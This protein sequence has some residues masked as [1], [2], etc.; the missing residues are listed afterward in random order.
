MKRFDVYLRNKITKL[1]IYLNELPIRDYRSLR[2][3]IIL[4]DKCS[5]LLR[6]FAAP[7]QGRT[8]LKIKIGTVSKIVRNSVSNAMTF[9]SSVFPR[10]ILYMKDNKNTAVLTTSDA[11]VSIGKYTGLR[12]RIMLRANNIKLLFGTPI[13][14]VKNRVTLDAKRL[15][16]TKTVFEKLSNSFVLTT[17]AVARNLSE[18][19]TKMMTVK[20]SM[21]LNSM[22]HAVMLRY[23]RLYE[24]DD[25]TL[26]SLDNM[27]LRDLDYIEL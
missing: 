18:T 15:S 2:H 21:V 22:V 12:Q 16:F 19:V 9:T 11:T 24:I 8:T 20:G 25:L 23:R 14:P 17:V 3:R 5:M 27:A 6:M 1:T 13:T 26:A 10:L 4:T 7:E